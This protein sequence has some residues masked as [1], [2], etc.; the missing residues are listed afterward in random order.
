MAFDYSAALIPAASSEREEAGADRIPLDAGAIAPDGLDDWLVE[1]SWPVS[2][3]AFTAFAKDAATAYWGAAQ[4]LDNFTRIGLLSD[5]AFFGFLLQHLHLKAAA[6]AYEQAGAAPVSGP[7]TAPYLMPDWSAMAQAYADQVGFGPRLKLRARAWAKSWVFNQGLGL[8]RRLRALGQGRKVW[9]LGS[10][11]DLMGDVGKFASEPV[12]HTF[13]DIVVPPAEPLVPSTAVETMIEML[14]V[15]IDDS[16]QRHLSV[17]LDREAVRSVWL[18]RVAA[19]AG[20]A[21]A[22]AKAARRPQCL[23]LTNMGNARHRL[24]ALVWRTQGTEV[25]GFHHGNEMGVERNPMMGL[26]ELSLCDRYVVPTAT[27]AAWFD[28]VQ[29]SCFVG[30]RTAFF[31]AESDRYLRLHA[32]LVHA[33]A[34]TP[35]QVMIVGFPLSWI[36]YPGYPAHFSLLQLD[37]ELRLATL[38][39]EHGYRV[40]IKVHPEWRTL[41][42]RLWAGRADAVQT[43]PFEKVW[44]ESAVLLFPRISSTTFGYALCTGRPVVV[45]ETPQGDWNPEAVPLLQRRCRFVQSHIDTDNRQRFD[46]VAL[47]AAVSAPAGDPDDDYLKTAMLPAKA[48]A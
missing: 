47:L 7:I 29:Q 41:A 18:R 12:H 11:T 15:G 9:A 30:A 10:Y 26:T 31:S 23:L 44:P 43:E 1:F 8:R 17:G 25:I 19:L 13:A 3:D 5:F 45:L 22:L 14:V 35:K 16:A 6:A 42:E 4:S 39:R 34:A 40:V 48:A 2:D 21:A 28:W 24:A 27:S 36:R 37:L 46:A 33:P 20:M 38:L 32:S